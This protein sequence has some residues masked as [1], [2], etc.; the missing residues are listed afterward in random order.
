M[1]QNHQDTKNEHHYLK[2]SGESSHWKLNDYE[3]EITPKIMSS[4]NG[5]LYFKPTDNNYVTEYYDFGMRAIINNEETTLQKQV[6]S[7]P[8]D[9]KGG[10]NTGSVEGP[11]FF[12][13][14]RN[15]I[16]LEDVNEIYAVIKWE[17]NDGKMQEETISLYVKKAKE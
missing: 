9:F 15:P 14:T 16:M 12:T 7:G 13:K 8:E 3:I 1:Y 10:I 2:L 17:D 5:K 4:G 11:A 6:V